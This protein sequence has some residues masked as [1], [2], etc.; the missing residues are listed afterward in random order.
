MTGLV[1]AIHVFLYHLQPR[2]GCPGHL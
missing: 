1:P 2:R